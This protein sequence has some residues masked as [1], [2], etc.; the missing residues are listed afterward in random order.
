MK[1]NVT[2][3]ALLL[4]NKSS[5]SNDSFGQKNVSKLFSLFLSFIL[6]QSVDRPN[7]LYVYA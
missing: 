5:T 3:P 6:R 4:G 1:N 2:T 7:Y